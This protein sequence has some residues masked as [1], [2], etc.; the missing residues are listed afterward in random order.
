MRNKRIST[1]EPETRTITAF[2]AQNYEFQLSLPKRRLSCEENE[3]NL[4]VLFAEAERARHA[5]VGHLGEALVDEE[6][7]ARRQVAMNEMVLFQVLHGRRHLVH[8][9][10]YITL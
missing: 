6:N 2:I 7:V 10:K 8:E 3:T 1:L 9:Q 4:V 5:K